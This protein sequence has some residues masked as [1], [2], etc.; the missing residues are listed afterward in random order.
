ML[1]ISCN[2]LN[3]SLVFS[4]LCTHLNR[5]SLL[6]SPDNQ[7]TFYFRCHFTSNVIDS[8]FLF[9]VIIS[10]FIKRQFRA[11][12]YE[13]RIR[14][15]SICFTYD[16]TFVVFR[17]KI[18]PSIEKSPI[19]SHENFQ[20]F[21]VACFESF[22][23]TISSSSRKII[24]PTTTVL[25]PSTLELKEGQIYWIQLEPLRCSLFIP[26]FLRFTEYFN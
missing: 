20:K 25:Q 11:I 24:P 6:T 8:T 18:F 7:L 1:L 22:A 2:P 21:T 19:T 26:P 10:R 3:L 14:M 9:S 4:A 17:H 16:T 23:I 15:N 5:L 13:L 12:R